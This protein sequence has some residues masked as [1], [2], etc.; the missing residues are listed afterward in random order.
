MFFTGTF[1][2]LFSSTLLS[3][4]HPIIS[5]LI[6]SDPWNSINKR[7]DGFELYNSFKNWQSYKI[8]NCDEIA[9]DEHPPFKA[10]KKLA[11]TNQEV[12]I[13][14]YGQSL[15][16]GKWTQLLEEWLREEYPKGN[17][18][19]AVHSRGGC[20]SQCLVG[21]R[22]WAIDNKQY[23]RLPQD[24]FEFNPD[25]IIF[26]VFGAHDDY[27][28][29]LRAF[30]DGCSV[31][32]NDLEPLVRCTE[33]T[34]FSDSEPPEVLVQNDPRT[35]IHY[36]HPDHSGLPDAT[37][38]EQV[39]EGEWNHWMTSIFIP[40]IVKKNDYYL[41]NN[42]KDMEAFLDMTNQTAND[43]SLKPG[44]IHFGDKGHLLNAKATASHLCYGE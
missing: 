44:D 29:I 5:N 19:F 42:W 1:L 13:L 38:A 10:I 4:N 35:G 7:L 9:T 20:S 14:V 18:V 25:L 36:P 6:K 26:H 30:K 33:S 2:S 32:A 27:E 11:T 3:Y 12:R 23:N 16:E 21:R 31:F 37:G 17:L 34:T 15:S 8:G 22:P 24:V 28:K 39:P 40:Q 43:I 41:Q